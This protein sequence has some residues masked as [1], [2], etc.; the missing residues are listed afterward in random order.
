MSTIIKFGD[1]IVD[2]DGI[3]NELYDYH[4]P[5][6]DLWDSKEFEYTGPLIWDWLI[7]ITEKAWITKDNVKDLNTAFVFA[8]DYFKSLKLSNVDDV[9]LAQ[10]L[11]IQQ[12]IID[13]KEDETPNDKG[14]KL[15]SGS[16]NESIK[17]YLNARN[18]I[19]YL[20]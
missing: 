10:T 3:S 15:V 9:S 4:I 2:E 12:Q 8:Q 16:P 19:K 18:N 20:P 13:I 7:H 1:W 5:K 11:Y 17:K 6:D 14:T